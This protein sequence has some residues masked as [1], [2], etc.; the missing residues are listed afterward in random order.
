M[1]HKL[2]L[3]KF[4]NIHALPILHYRMEFASLA[5][6]AADE[7]EPDCIAVEL[8]ATLEAAFLKGV[9]RLPQISV[10]MFEVAS[11]SKKREAEARNVFLMI[12]P[13]DAIVEAARI[14]LERNIPCHCVDAD[15]DDY[16]GHGEIMPDSYAV[17]RIGLRAYY[18]E[19]VRMFGNEAPHPLDMRREQAMAY[20]LR[21]LSE[22]HEKVL[23]I[24]GMAHLERIRRQ[25]GHPQ[26]APLERTRRD[27]ILLFNLHPDSCREV[28]SEFPFLSSVYE[29]RRGPL[30][31]EPVRDGKSLR[32]SFHAFELVMG[33]K[34]DIPEEDVLRDS[35]IRCA[36]RAGKEGE[37]VDRQRVILRLFQETSG[38]YRQETGEPVHI[39]QKRAFF[40]FSRNYALTSGML[41]P[42]LYQMLASARGCVDDNFAYAFHRLATFYPW[43]QETADIPTIRVSPEDVWGGSRKIRF[44]LKSRQKGKGLSHLQFLKRKRETRPGEWLEG[45]DNPSICSYPPEDLVIEDYGRFLRKKGAKQL[46]EEH[47][48]VEEFTASLL[49][50]I[51]MRETLRNIHEGKIYVRENQRVKGGVGSVVVI[52]DEDRDMK[53]F[54]YL[55]TWLGEHEQESDM[56]FYGTLPTDNIVGP[57]I[58]RCEYG[59]FML[60]YPPRRMYDVWQDGDYRFV[61][62][63]SEVLLLAALDYSTEKHVVYVST[64]PPRS[65]FKQLAAR[66][67]RNIVYIPL[68]SLS[69]LKLKKIR[70]FHVLFGHDKRGIAH[71]YIW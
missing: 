35:V 52:F 5:R 71:D 64:R 39:W 42:D 21:A 8:P 11:P 27:H 61:R 33:G 6:Q 13:A 69:P 14:S 43:Q 68:G 63:K 34:Q 36:H 38:H 22:R 46:S 44:R 20:R 16:P 45:F 54:P 15:V 60:S 70:V 55:M 26:A 18:R 4:G 7:L 48:R 2:H 30:P 24:T 57:G 62:G 56:A 9:K 25:F 37:S 50:G 23:F 10:V 32:K 59:G 49:D 41:L 3:E 67:G 53:K 19:F 47:S 1:P 31:A 17:R 12:E 29:M 28:L 51:D 40:R 65:F 58:S 66:M